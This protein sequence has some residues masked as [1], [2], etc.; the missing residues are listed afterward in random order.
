MFVELLDSLTRE[1]EV[2]LDVAD[3]GT[4]AVDHPFAMRLDLGE[5]LEARTNPLGSRGDFRRLH[6]FA[7]RAL[8]GILGHALPPKRAR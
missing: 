5:V 1:L 7:P 8:F 4:Q 6:A 3:V 2:V